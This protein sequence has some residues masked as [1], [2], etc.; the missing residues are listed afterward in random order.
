MAPRPRLFPAAVIFGERVRARRKR[1]N[2]SQENLAERCDL[3]WTY[4]GGVE[5][6]TR[7]VS[8]ENLLRIAYGLEVDLADLVRELPLPPQK[9]K[10]TRQPARQTTT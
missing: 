3:H 6:G 7:N 5:R 10:P 1:L 9:V 4:V 2:L 8:L